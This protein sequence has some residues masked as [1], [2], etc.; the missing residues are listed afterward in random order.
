MSRNIKLGDSSNADNTDSPDDIAD[1]V[2]RQLQR[3]REESFAEQKAA[4]AA[5]ADD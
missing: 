2:T 4:E 3:Q 5:E 1:S